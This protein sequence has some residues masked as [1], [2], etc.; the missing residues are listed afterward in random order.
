[1]VEMSGV[2]IKASDCELSLENE[3]SRELN[4][5]IDLLKQS[6]ENIVSLTGAKSVVAFEQAGGATEERGAS[7]DSVTDM[8]DVISE[9]WYCTCTVARLPFFQIFKLLSACS[10]KI[11]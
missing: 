3:F 5:T 7:Q 2:N 1:M 9:E 6:S 4:V 8:Y 10:F 11:I